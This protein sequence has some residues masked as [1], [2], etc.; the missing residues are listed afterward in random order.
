[1]ASTA[2][3]RRRGPGLVPGRLPAVAV[4][5]KGADLTREKLLQAAHELLFDRAGAE[6]SVSQICERAGVQVAMVSYCFGGKA[7]LLDALVERTT[8]VVVAELDRCAALELAPEEK[9]RLHIAAVIQNF[10]RYPYVSRLSER[11]LADERAAARSAAT[12]ARPSIAFYRELLADGTARH[13]WREV[14]PTF[15]FLS[16]VGMCEFLFAGRSWL[17]EAGGHKLNDKLIERFT[18]HTVQ[19]V[20]EGLRRH[21]G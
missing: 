8:T 5:P 4:P 21:G 9:L 6:P 14:D 17:E 19:L 18:E 11:L 10:V 20:I 13:G 3:S 7:Q 16:L 15:F 2:S 1:M 12:F